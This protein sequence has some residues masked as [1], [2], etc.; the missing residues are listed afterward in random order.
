MKKVFAILLICLVMWIGC[1]MQPPNVEASQQEY[2]VKVYD[3]YEY[4]VVY[5]NIT[6]VMYVVSD[7]A[8]NRGT[9]TVLYDENGNVLLYE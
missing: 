8:S 3:D 5:D 9:F 4:Y 2:F 7:G 6:K 1:S